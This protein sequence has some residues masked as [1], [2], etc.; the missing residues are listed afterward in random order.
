MVA[1]HVKRR[2]KAE[3]AKKAAEAAKKAEEAVAVKPKRT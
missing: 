1:P 3:A 2:R